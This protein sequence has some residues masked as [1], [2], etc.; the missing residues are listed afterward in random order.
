MRLAYVSLAAIALASAAPAM[1]QNLITN[2]NFSAGLSNWS[3]SNDCCWYTD[4]NGFR[5]G[6]VGD[7]SYLSQTFGDSAGQMLTLDYDFTSDAGSQFVLFNGV[8]V[9]NSYSGP[10]GWTHYTFTL[11]LATGSDTI[12]FRGRND[13][14]YS[15]LTNVSVTQSPVPETA[16]WA[17]MLGG[18]GMVG[19]ALR[20]RKTKV[21]FA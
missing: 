20:S 10:E 15:A 2:G 12:T 21:A 19:G 4:S 17:L 13:P 8:E 18:F 3:L 14:S 16:T 7:Y 1:A 11:G 5:E 6:A 9:P